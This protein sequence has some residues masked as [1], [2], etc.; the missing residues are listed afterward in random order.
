MV[1]KKVLTIWFASN[2]ILSLYFILRRIQLEKTLREQEEEG[3]TFQEDMQVFERRYADFSSI[4]EHGVAQKKKVQEHKK[5]SNWQCTFRI[6]KKTTPEINQKFPLLDDVIINWLGRDF[7]S[8]QNT[9]FKDM[10]EVADEKNRFFLIYVDKYDVDLAFN[11]QLVNFDHFKIRNYLFIAADRETMIHLRSKNMECFLFSHVIQKHDKFKVIFLALL[12]GFN[13]IISDTN[14]IFLQNPT[15]HLNYNNYDIA[16]MQNDS[17]KELN[18]A[19]GI[20]YATESTI[21]FFKQTAEKL[22]LSTYTA[23]ESSGKIFSNIDQESKIKIAKLDNAKFQSGTSYYLEGRHE[24]FESNNSCTAC[25]AVHNSGIQTKAAKIYRLKEGLKWEAEDPHY[26]ENPEAKY[27]TYENDYT[28]EDIAAV[29]EKALKA[30]F[31]IAITLNRILILP[32]LNC[33][34]FKCN[35]LHRYKIEALETFLRGKYRESAFLHHR[36]VPDSIRNGHSPKFKI[37]PL[38]EK[39]IKRHKGHG[40]QTFLSTTLDEGYLDIAEIKNWII[41]SRRIY[42]PILNFQSLDFEVRGFNEYLIENIEKGL[43]KSDYLQSAECSS[44]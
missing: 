19:F 43:C 39:Q 28:G 16:M 29:E 24:F 6:Y 3:R 21:S 2:A 20:I 25:V 33:K 23:E 37:A 18:E 5:T 13:L 36:F 26:F 11:I 22:A 38:S 15:T 44:S 14:M 27:M 30:A 35:I 41:G 32:K 1:K 40:V 8:Y 9:L 12:Y 17:G 34:G 4:N 31:V 10:Y 42:F 7:L